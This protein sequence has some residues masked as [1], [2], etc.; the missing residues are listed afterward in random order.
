MS[1]GTPAFL[2]NVT[3]LPPD[4]WPNFVSVWLRQLPFSLLPIYYLLTT[5]E[6][7][8]RWS[9]SSVLP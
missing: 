8:L 5:L 1:V 9:R 7:R 6:K 3:S 4:K 2:T